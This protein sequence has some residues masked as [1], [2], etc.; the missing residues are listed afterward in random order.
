MG[1][2]GGTAVVGQKLLEAIFGE[3]AVRRLAKEA[4]RSLEVRS[5]SL[6]ERQQQHFLDR[7]GP[8]ETAS[9]TLVERLE[10]LA[11][12][13]ADLG[14]RSDDQIGGQSGGQKPGGK[15]SAGQGESA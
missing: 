6:L 11:A 9:T 5:A 4:K 10:G 13:L 3:D 12:E 14:G 2:A 8:A 1:I 15:R 7:L